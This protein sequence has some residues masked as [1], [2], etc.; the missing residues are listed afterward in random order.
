M[1]AVP[2]NN[3]PA[4][5]PLS[6]EGTPAISS[7][8]PFFNAGGPTAL[9]AQ[10]LTDGDSP[11]NFEDI[12]ALEQFGTAEIDQPPPISQALAVASLLQSPPAQELQELPIADS[13]EAQ[14]PH[15]FPDLAQEGTRDAATWHMPHVA[16]ATMVAANAL[17]AESLPTDSSKLNLESLKRIATSPVGDALAS[18]ETA[19]HLATESLEI[20]AN[21]PNASQKF[22]ID[23]NV[24]APANDSARSAASPLL[25][26]THGEQKQQAKNITSQGD[27]LLRE[28][29]SESSSLL[30]TLSEIDSAAEAPIQLVDPKISSETD[31]S[32]DPPTI[33]TRTADAPTEGHLPSPLANFATSTPEQINHFT[34]QSTTAAEL[35]KTVADNLV[36]QV[37]LTDQGESKQLKL[38]LHPA[39]LGQVT[40]QVDWENESLKVKLLTN[41]SAANEILNQNRSELVAAL[42]EEGIDF[43]SLEIS[44]DRDNTGTDQG[45]HEEE[46]ERQQVSPAM[47]ATSDSASQSSQP[48][49][50]H[51]T[52]TLDIT[53]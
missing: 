17:D 20:I 3:L 53:V 33:P 29:D 25:S 11:F 30:Q 43:D 31:S 23:A 16:P 10:D 40:L 18:D 48:A 12:L 14:P 15:E 34:P 27:S 7:I 4:N 42:A 21:A 24:L 22:A 26:S 49:S 2:G 13:S 37:T 6:G 46:T 41:E 50:R 5:S 19:E 45:P 52:T 47:F 44:Y 51:S 38:Q 28:S 32:T 39:E 9:D 35:T 36:Q 8:V 1:N